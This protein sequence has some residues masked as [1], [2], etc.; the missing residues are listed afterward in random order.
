MPTTMPNKV[1]SYKYVIDT[2]Y[3]SERTM[4]HLLKRL[5]NPL[6]WNALITDVERLNGS[7]RIAFTASDSVDS[8]LSDLELEVI[9]KAE[10]LPN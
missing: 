1:T 5:N 4:F 8:L 10:I 3:R 9:L 6:K 2:H 7:S